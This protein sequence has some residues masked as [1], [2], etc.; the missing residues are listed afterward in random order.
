MVGGYEAARYSVDRK[1]PFWPVLDPLFEVDDAD[2]WMLM[3]RARALFANSAEVKA[4]VKGIC[5]H[6]GW[7]MPLPCTADEEWNKAA[8]EAFISRVEDA[9]LFECS[10]RLNWQQA[11]LWIEKHSM[12]DGD[13]LTVLTESETDGGGRVALYRAH[14]LGGHG[15]DAKGAFV[16]GCRLGAMGRVESYLLSRGRGQGVSEIPA[17]DCLLYHH[18]PDPA[19]VRGVTPLAAILNSAQDVNEINQYTKAS[20]K[21]AASFALFEEKPV[22]DARPDVA[23]LIKKRRGEDVP[24][25]PPPP[26]E[27]NGVK[28]VSLA[29]GRKVSILHDNRPSDS[30]RALNKDLLRAI[31]Y[32]MNIDPEVVFFVV[33]M[34]SASSRFSLEKL[35]GFVKEMRIERKVWANKVYRHVL[36]AEMREGRLRDCRDPHWHKVAWV[37]CRDKTIDKARVGSLQINLVREGLADANSWTLATEGL[38]VVEIAERRARDLARVRDICREHDVP[39]SWVMQGALGAVAAIEDKDGDSASKVSKQ[40][41]YEDEE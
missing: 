32:S 16:R 25:E 27:V 17:R 37:S 33:D 1:A 3:T 24:D 10:G 36:A 9:D 19:A 11:Q 38:T 5:S 26:A 31:A 4:V 23:S 15:V 29:P 28:I 35:D 12:I 18:E 6:I 30:N 14:Q 34:A 22:G 41:A 20:V 2:A 8:R 13:T 40:D 39:L 21:L 7:L